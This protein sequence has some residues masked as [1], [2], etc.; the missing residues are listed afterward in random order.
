MKK[1]TAILLII[2]MAIGL[3]GCT[4]NGGNEDDVNVKTQT[5][6]AETVT[7]SSLADTYPAETFRVIVPYAAGG[8]ADVFNR[9]FAKYLSEELDANV[10]VEN[11]PGAGG[12][13]ATTN[14]LKEEANTTTVL[15]SNSSIM[16]FVPKAQEVAYKRADFIP[17]FSAQVLKFG[18]YACPEKTG[19]ETLEDLTEYAKDNKIIFGSPGVG[20]PIYAT[21]KILYSQL[22]AESDTVTHNNG[23]QGMINVMAGTV[24][25]T[26][27]SV[28][29]A[30]SH[31][32]EGN[33]VPLAVLSKE[34]VEMESG[35][36]PSISELGYDLSNDI[37][38]MYLIRT[39]TDQAVV[40]KLNTAFNNVVN[41]DTFMEEVTKI[42]DSLWKVMEIDEI[43]TFL[44]NV[45]LQSEELI[46]AR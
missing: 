10:V 23:N 7:E 42:Q 36:I 38:T 28:T 22:G 45:E 5:D 27:N 46:S 14:Y 8:G 35:Y 4:S 18:L 40:D 39:G 11:M 19:I 33:V 20:K 31:V 21:Q 29:A 16:S 12:V 17:F 32:A 30:E 43:N 26:I 1:L 6:G 2:V 41:N 34:G 3:V 15:Y 13:V 9:V 25:V 24:A 37:L 44:D